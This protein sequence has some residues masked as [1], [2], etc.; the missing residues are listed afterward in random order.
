MT[1]LLILNKKRIFLKPLPNFMARFK[2]LYACKAL[3]SSKEF[4]TDIRKY[5]LVPGPI[6]K[7]CVPVSKA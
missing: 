3:L 4:M 1:W 2:K 6:Y 7:G 5:K